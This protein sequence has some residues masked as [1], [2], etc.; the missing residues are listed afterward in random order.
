MPKLF[1]H[2]ITVLTFLCCLCITIAIPL[3]LMWYLFFGL[4]QI[5]IKTIILFVLSVIPIFLVY[6]S[7]N[8]AFKISP[9][10]FLGGIIAQK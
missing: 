4:S 8:E 7:K 9:Q 10:N 3:A 5:Y 1:E 2:I 6:F